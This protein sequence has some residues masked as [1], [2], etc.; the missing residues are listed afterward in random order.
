M[1]VRIRLNAGPKVTK[2]RRKNRHIALAMASLLTPAAV[3]AFVLGF[4]R[5]VADLKVTSEFPITTGLFSHWQVW[6]TG[7]AMLQLCALLLNRYGSAQYE[8]SQVVFRKT[9]EKARRRTA[10]TS[11]F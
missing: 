9:V 3:M 5:L 6:I 2:K 11:G 8:N 4:W 7:A 1:L 10:V